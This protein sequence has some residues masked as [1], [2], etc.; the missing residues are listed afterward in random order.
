VPKDLREAVR[1]CRKADA[2]GDALAAYWM[3]SASYFGRGVPKDQVLAS[4]LVPRVTALLSACAEKG[5]LECMERLQ[6]SYQHDFFSGKTDHDLATRMWEMREAPLRRAAETGDLVDVFEYATHLT[7]APETTRD[8][9]KARALLQRAA[10]GGLPAAMHMYGDLLWSGS[11]G[12][13]DPD[14]ALRWLEKAGELGYGSGYAAL[15]FKYEY[16]LK[17]PA[18]SAHYYEKATGYSPYYFAVLAKKSLVGWPGAPADPRAALA[19]AY[20]GA[21]L[22]DGESA[23]VLARLY[24][25][26]EGTSAETVEAY[27]WALIAA[28]QGASNEFLGPLEKSLKPAEL[29]EGRRRADA[30]VFETAPLPAPWPARGA[31]AAASAPAAPAPASPAP[32]EPV[33]TLPERRHDYALV[34]GIEKY[35]GLP[36][37]D[38]A[39][40]DA[41][42][43]RERLVA[44]GFPR[45]NVVTLTGADATRSKLAAYLEEWLPR[46]ASKDGRVFFYFSG[47][48]SP[49]VKT[50][51]AFL[52][53]ADGDPAFLKSTAY[54]LKDLYASLEALPAKQVIV[55][56]DSCFSGA[57]GRSV[58]AKG[59]RPL[60][61]KVDSG[62]G[63]AG[64]KLVVLA[65]A[66]G[67]QVT[68]GLD[69]QRRGA[70]THFLL[71][72]LA[73]AALDEKGRITAGGLSE[74]LSP[75]VADSARRQNREQTP[76]LYGD[77]DAVLFSR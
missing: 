10:E 1:L 46:N 43:V 21:K 77:A 64:G 70:F 65:A 54:P 4:K 14:A 59:M 3:W 68:G 26:G 25:K 12:P 41:E 42:A 40:S 34:V 29:A 8:L 38:Y 74:Y 20:R 13:K 37:A 9:K 39:E 18:K 76:A 36:A 75:R 62:A 56:L 32:T 6:N 35:R 52:V 49:D 73:G 17:D 2:A 27:K 31:T 55:A 44:L 7:W 72:G 66:A 28:R 67:D 24:S 45:R 60:V 16:E 58:L 5:D 30:F 57:G 48:G 11:G 63:G 23:A 71:E 47:H 19:H 53:P 33:L 69:E 15:G 51:Q 22:G 50:G 61:A